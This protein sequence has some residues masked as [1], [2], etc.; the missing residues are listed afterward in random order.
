M[1]GE[2]KWY[3]VHTYSGYEERAKQ[4][5][6]ELAKNEGCEEQFG[7]VFIP[8]TVSESVSKSGKRRQ[9]QDIFPRLYVGSNGPYRH[10]NAYRQKYS[11]DHWLCGEHEEAPAVA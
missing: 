7:E 1:S 2:F 10:D 6:I 4:S 3:V 8:Q 5:L 11:K 9:F